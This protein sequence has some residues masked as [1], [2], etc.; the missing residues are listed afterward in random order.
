MITG[1]L[2]VIQVRPASLPWCPARQQFAFIA[3]AAG[4]RRH[5]SIR[6]DFASGAS[7]QMMHTMSPLHDKQTE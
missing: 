5:P 2:P 1:E 4:R 6:D 3:T 7:Q